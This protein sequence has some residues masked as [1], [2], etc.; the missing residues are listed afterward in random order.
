MSKQQLI[1]FLK[2]KRNIILLGIP[3]SGISLI[4]KNVAQKM[5]FGEVKDT[6]TKEEQ[7][8]FEL[9]CGFVQFHPSYDYNNFVEGLVPISDE[10]GKAYHILRYGVFKSF[11]SRALLNPDQPYVFIIDEIN[12]GDVSKI[13]G[14]LYF[15]IDPRC[16]GEIGKVQTQYANMET[17]PNVFDVELDSSDFGHFFVPENVFIIGTMIVY[18]KEVERM[19]IDFLNKFAFVEYKL[20]GSLK[21]LDSLN[22]NIAPSIIDTKI[23]NDTPQDYLNNNNQLIQKAIEDGDYDS[24]VTK[25]RTIIE[26]CYCYGIEQKGLKILGDGELNSLRKQFGDLYGITRTN[27]PTEVEKNINDIYSG[28]NKIADAIGRLRNKNSDAHGVG[29]ARL[30]FKECEARLISNSAKTICEYLLSIII[31]ETNKTV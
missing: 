1:D 6:M 8:Q 5:I 4:A 26:E 20:D 25:C 31:D 28:I 9:Q 10:D 29:A 24:V 17:V 19:D 2:D 18:N 3:K 14:D 12:R 23:M 11:C 7:Q 15:S 21:F 30:Q 27:N 16:R 22:L 13:F